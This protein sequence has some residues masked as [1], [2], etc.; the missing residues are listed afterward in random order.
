LVL[1]G[2]LWLSSATTTRASTR[3]TGAVLG[4]E[5]RVQSGDVTIVGGSPS[6][7][8]VSHTDRSVFG[9]R[10]REQRSLNG[11]IVRIS[12]SCSQLVVGRCASDYQ[13]DVPDNVPISVRAESGAV[14]LSGYHGSAD[15]ATNGGAI[16]VE[17]YCGFVLGA[18][19]ASGDV[20]VQAACSPERLT[21]RSDSGNVSALVPSGSYR[22]Q[23][24]SADGSIR[25]RGVTNDNGAPWAIEALSNSGDVKVA[26][27]S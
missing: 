6:G 18:A 16:T 8:W 17:G 27:S 4:I 25:V 19:S 13:V 1:L 14:H 5:L 20:S 11:G 12:S 24:G 10:P 3:L 26:S 7:I 23:A 21:L 15:I 22:I 9:H 2:A